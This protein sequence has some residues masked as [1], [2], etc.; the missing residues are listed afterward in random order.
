MIGRELQYISQNNFLQTLIKN[1]C[2]LEIFTVISGK[3]ATQ[4]N[5]KIQ[6]CI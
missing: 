4:F 1:S 5:Y 6:Q 3:Q 2:A